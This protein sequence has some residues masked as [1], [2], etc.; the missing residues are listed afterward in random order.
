MSQQKIVI[1]V[2][3]LA[4]ALSEAGL[5]NVSITVGAAAAGTLVVNN[6][7][8]GQT[9]ED[10]TNTSSRRT[11]RGA[12]EQKEDAKE[13]AA[14][15]GEKTQEQTEKPA[16]SRRGR[17]AANKE[18]SEAETTDTK[19]GRGRRTAK[20]VDPVNDTPEQAEMREN[21]TADLRVLADHDEAIDDVTAALQRTG[22]TSIKMVPSDL[23]EDF[24]ADIGAI[25]EKYKLN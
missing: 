19:G 24:D 6:F 10:T 3:A 21:L 16:G 4:A 9:Q 15:A 23:L 25:F 20:K 18:T 1:A 11:R 14:D 7:V 2:Q 12:A 22:A 8:D 5:A 17:G 13:E